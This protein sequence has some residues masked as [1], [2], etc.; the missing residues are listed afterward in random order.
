VEETIASGWLVGE[1]GKEQDD[2]TARQG[3]RPLGV[4]FRREPF[5]PKPERPEPRLVSP[6]IEKGRP[7]LRPVLTEMERGRPEAH[8]SERPRNAVN[9]DDLRS[10]LE[11]ALVRGKDLRSGEKKRDNSDNEKSKQLN[12]APPLFIIYDTNSFILSRN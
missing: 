1:K 2:K 6:G 3:E 11:N 4:A 12:I 7:E 8:P 5:R 9:I 10:A